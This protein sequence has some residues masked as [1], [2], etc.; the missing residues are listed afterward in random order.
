MKQ[1]A[2]STDQSPNFGRSQSPIDIK[3]D[4]GEDNDD[5]AFITEPPAAAKTIGKS[6]N[7]SVK[8]GNTYFTQNSKTVLHKLPPLKISEVA[9]SN[10]D[11]NSKSKSHFP[12]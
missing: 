3:I 10:F 5:I 11:Q 12:R 8:P 9:P 4:N 2:Y 1:I 6:R 7:N